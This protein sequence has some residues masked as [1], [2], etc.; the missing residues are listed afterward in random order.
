ME[1][2]YTD[3]LTCAQLVKMITTPRTGEKHRKFEDVVDEC[4]SQIDEVNR[5]ATYKLY[6][7]ATNKSLQFM[8][9]GSIMEHISPMRINQY[10]S[11]LKKRSFR[12]RQSTS[13]L[14]F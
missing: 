12:V 3:S 11:W 1:L 14:H 13:I 4:L 10:I 7:L 2:E 5:T 6:K 8:G 9:L